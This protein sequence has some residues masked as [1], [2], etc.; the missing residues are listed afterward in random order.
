MLWKL[1]TLTQHCVY[2]AFYQLQFTP[3]ACSVPHVPLYQDKP[4]EAR[5]ALRLPS[6]SR[7]R[8]TSV[9]SHSAHCYLFTLD[10]ADDST[11][12][13]SA[14][15]AMTFV[16]SVGYSCTC[17]CDA[18]C[19]PQCRLCC[20]QCRL[21]C[22]HCRLLSPMQAM[23]T[24]MQTAVPNAGYVVMSLHEGRHVDSDYSAGA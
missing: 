17:V 7:Q 24:P 3:T 5:Q 4:E 14:G 13:H 1:C 2:Y 10:A 12:F 16:Y 11:C 8:L 23:L 9:S 20:P 22:P 15:H 6:V 21:C 18:D 19:C